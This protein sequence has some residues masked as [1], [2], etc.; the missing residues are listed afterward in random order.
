MGV[1]R[2]RRSDLKI[3]KGVYGFVRCTVPKLLTIISANSKVTRVQK[4][5]RSLAVKARE[6]V[7]PQA[8]AF[9]V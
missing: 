4:S 6:A 5:L 2:S 1:N 3:H 9:A 7:A 8:Y